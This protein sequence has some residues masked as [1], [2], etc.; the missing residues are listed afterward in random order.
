MYNN[1]EKKSEYQNIQ[2]SRNSLNIFEQFIFNV[3]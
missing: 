2:V 3:L 1:I